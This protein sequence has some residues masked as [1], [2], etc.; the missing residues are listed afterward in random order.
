MAFPPLESPDTPLVSDPNATPWPWSRPPA[1]S[2][3]ALDA[4]PARPARDTQPARG[5]RHAVLSGRE[6]I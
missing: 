6:R 3:P 5:T 2:G 1:S 4:R